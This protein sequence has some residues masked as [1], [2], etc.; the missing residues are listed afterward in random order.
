LTA[1][2]TNINNT[3][4]SSFLHTVWEIE[5]STGDRQQTTLMDAAWVIYKATTNWPAKLRDSA[6]CTWQSKAFVHKCQ[7]LEVSFDDGNRELNKGTKGWSS[8]WKG[9]VDLNFTTSDL[10]TA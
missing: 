2:L 6:N 1:M 5:V 4:N 10:D 3:S 9:R 7:P 8:V